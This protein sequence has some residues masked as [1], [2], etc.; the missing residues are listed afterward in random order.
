MVLP[1]VGSLLCIF[2]IFGQTP[3][4]PPAEVPATAP[5][6]AD[7]LFPIERWNYEAGGRRDPF[8]PLVGYALSEGGKA[9]HLTVENMNLIGILWGDKGYYALIKDGQNNGYILRKG[10]KVASGEV[11]EVNNQA[12]VFDIMHAG[13]V[14][15]FEL[16][17]QG[18][19]R[20]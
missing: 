3:T 5:T 4:P 15:K 13:V 17:L 8:V 19:G 9:S 2:V 10:D 18:K 6:E 12:I 14:T 16:R 1:L 7:T 11:V 20:R